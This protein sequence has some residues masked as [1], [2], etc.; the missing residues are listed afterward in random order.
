MKDI[1][2]VYI[3]FYN[4]MTLCDHQLVMVTNTSKIIDTE[5]CVLIDLLLF[6]RTLYREAG[7]CHH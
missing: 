4:K 3:V 5:P 7:I 6:G 2:V 1:M